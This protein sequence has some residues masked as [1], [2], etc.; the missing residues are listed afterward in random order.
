[1]NHLGPENTAADFERG[2]AQQA[3]T[4]VVIGEIAARVA[5][6]SLAVVEFRAVEKIVGDG[7]ADLVDAGGVGNASQPDR[8][9]IENTAAFERD[10]AIPRHQYR[11]V[12]ADCAQ[13]LR[14]GADHVR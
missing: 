10:P 4:N 13:S 8:K 7:F 11:D 2:P 12:L 14:Q 3:E 6:Q 9:V 1:M 5:I